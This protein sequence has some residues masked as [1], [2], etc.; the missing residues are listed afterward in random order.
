MDKIRIN[1]KDKDIRDKIRIK[2][3]IRIRNKIRINGP[4]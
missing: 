3:Q 4:D 2:G 1:G